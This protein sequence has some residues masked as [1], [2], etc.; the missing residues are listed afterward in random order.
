MNSVKLTGNVGREINVREFDGNKIVTFT[1][2]TNESYI[3]KAKDQVKNTVWHSIIVWGQA[4]QQCE[5]WIE[6]GKTV[7]IEGKL[8]YRQYVNKEKLTVKLAEVLAFKV[9]A[10][11]KYAAKV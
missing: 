8:T 11:A 9:E 10:V 6:K 7:S 3:S 4:A 2:A 1:L 5:D